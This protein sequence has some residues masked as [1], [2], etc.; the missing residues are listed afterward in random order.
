MYY[1]DSRLEKLLK[2]SNNLDRVLYYKSPTEAVLKKIDPDG[3]SKSMIVSIRNFETYSN[4]TESRIKNIIIDKM[5]DF[6][7]LEDNHCSAMSLGHIGFFSFT[8]GPSI[9]M[10]TKEID[11]NTQLEIVPSTNSDIAAIKNPYIRT[12]VAFLNEVINKSDNRFEMTTPVQ[13]YED[14]FIFYIWY[15]IDD[16]VGLTSKN[17]IFKITLSQT[18]G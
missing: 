15:W 4:M 16:N 17:Q 14:K 7:F 18:R 9:R 3:T 6:S 1:I 10:D 11:E 5:R 8:D 2:L 12:I 13:D